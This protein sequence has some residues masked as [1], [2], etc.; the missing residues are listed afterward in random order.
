MMEVTDELLDRFLD[1]DASNDEAALLHDWLALPANMD[2]FAERAEIHADL[3]RSLH[4]RRIQQ[5]ALTA[6]GE[7]TS[8]RAFAE[9]VEP[10]RRRYKRRTFVLLAG[11]LATAAVL[12]I[13]F[14]RPDEVTL[15]D[16]SEA[17]IATLAY[18][19]HALWSDRERSAGDAIAPGVLQLEVGI[20]RLDF[21]NGATVTLQ[22]PS[23]FEV[24]SAVHTRL[25]SGILTASIPESAI[26][27]EVE[28]PAVDVVDLGTAF[29]VSVGSDGETDVCVFEG[30]VQ[31][32]SAGNDGGVQLLS[33]G[34]AVRSTPQ[35]SAIESVAYETNR[36]EDA[37]PVNSGVLQATGLMKFVAPGPEFVPGRFEDNDRILVFLERSGVVPTA[38]F[39]VDLVDPGQYQRIHRS[40]QHPVR[41]GGRIRS[42][43]LQLDPVGRLERGAPD[44][45]RVIGQVTFDRTIIGLIASSKNLDATDELLG[46]PRGDYVKARRGIEP[47]RSTDPPDSGR[48]VVVLSTDRRTLSLDLSA[49]TAVD[50]IRVVVDELN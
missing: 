23:E 3:R 32:R 37:W 18:E 7:N 38:D 43:L 24:M 11:V 46:H 36:F 8:G 28:T 4:R 21:S 31:V 29:G 12:M 27:F 6:C 49:G 17:V 42:Y 40:E 20:V 33:E 13:A 26:G 5:E 14:L 9:R 2:R 10:A 39:A 1:G 47:P 25:H 22:G 45:P 30:E 41:A 15:P 48:D 34:N 19:S 35:S 50:Q 44:K 16:P